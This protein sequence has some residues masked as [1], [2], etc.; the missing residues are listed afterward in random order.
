MA[1]ANPLKVKP[2]RG[3]P[4]VGVT[5]PLTQFCTLLGNLEFVSV[6]VEALLGDWPLFNTIPESAFDTEL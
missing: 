3:E 2:V 1:T 6:T 5:D 4:A